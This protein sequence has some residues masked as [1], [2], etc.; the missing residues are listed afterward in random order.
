MFWENG[1][2][3]VADSP[4]F[5]AGCIADRPVCESFANLKMKQTRQSALH[6]GRSRPLIC[7]F[8]EALWGV[9]V[10]SQLYPELILILI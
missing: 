9:G 1:H 2:L 6:P 8:F 3:D 10:Y 5:G 4:L 7:R